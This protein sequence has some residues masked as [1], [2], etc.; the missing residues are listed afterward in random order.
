MLEFLSRISTEILKDAD[1]FEARIPFQILNTMRDQQKELSIS[2]SLAFHNCRSCR[3]FSINT[4][5]APTDDMR[6]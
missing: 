1:V 4:S 6:S 5:C 2:A 3:T